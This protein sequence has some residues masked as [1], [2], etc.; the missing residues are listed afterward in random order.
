VLDKIEE[1]QLARQ[2][3]REALINHRHT[4]GVTGSGSSKRRET[5]D[6]F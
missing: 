2:I 1:P 4:L 6:G 3:R 5:I